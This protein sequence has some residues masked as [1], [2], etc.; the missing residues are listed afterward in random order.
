MNR[1][2]VRK[3]LN[4]LKRSQSITING[5]NIKRVGINWR[6]EKGTHFRKTYAENEIEVLIARLIHIEDELTLRKEARIAR[7]RNKREHKQIRQIEK[8]T[9]RNNRKRNKV[10]A[11]IANIIIQLSAVVL[12]ALFFF[13]TA[14]F[15]L[16]FMGNYQLFAVIGAG[17]IGLISHILYFR[18]LGKKHKITNTIW[19]FVLIAGL[20]AGS[21][22]LKDVINNILNNNVIGDSILI[23]IKN[24]AYASLMG[25]LVVKLIFS[26][27]FLK[28]KK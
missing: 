28:N 24:G 17:V 9:R 7:K 27:V 5:F 16:N 3:S 21:I 13:P 11:E 26:F 6:V 18:Q 2:Q 20:I 23:T 8:R 1:T 22:F 12:W 4:E 19:G 25:F 10:S 14:K 15:N